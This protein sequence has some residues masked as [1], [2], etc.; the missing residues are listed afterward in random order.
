[1]KRNLKA[2]ES[3]KGP[4]NGV[5]YYYEQLGYCS[6]QCRKRNGESSQQGNVTKEYNDYVAM[7]TKS[8][9]VDTNDQNWY[10][11]SGATKH[12]SRANGGF[13]E[14]KEIKSAN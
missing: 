3:T 5:C 8:M 7:V 12:I 14:L 4:K 2:I 13:I 1:M 10:N 11:D 9:I 6:S